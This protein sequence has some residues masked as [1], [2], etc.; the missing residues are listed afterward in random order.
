MAPAGDGHAGVSFLR[1]LFA[2]HFP[3]ILG[4]YHSCL[5]CYRPSRD[6]CS[7]LCITFAT[8]LPMNC[9]RTEMG[10]RSGW[11]S[12]AWVC[13]FVFFIDWVVSSRRAGATRPPKVL[14]V[15]PVGDRVVEPGPAG[16]D[17]RSGRIGEPGRGTSVPVGASDPDIPRGHR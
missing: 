3:G 15:G 11:R 5:G 1:K 2:P 14:A 13:F 9:D 7:E 8:G 10:Y 16:T 6:Y 4:G 12:P 17:R